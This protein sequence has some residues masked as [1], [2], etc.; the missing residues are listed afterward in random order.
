[1]GGLNIRGRKLLSEQV[2][3]NCE[4]C[5]R[6]FENDCVYCPEC[7]TKLKTVKTKI[8]ANYSKNGMTSFSYVLPNGITLNSKRGMTMSLGNGISYST[9]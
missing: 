2:L 6:L 3:M 8:Y 5:K 1:M 4:S 7:G 9:K